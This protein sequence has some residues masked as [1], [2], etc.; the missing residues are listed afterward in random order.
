ML[1]KPM[2]SQPHSDGL[3]PSLQ[4]KLVM[5]NLGP[6]PQQINEDSKPIPIYMK[7]SNTLADRYGRM[8]FRL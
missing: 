5:G 2:N 7:P 4:A 3:H 1:L 6:N 8:P